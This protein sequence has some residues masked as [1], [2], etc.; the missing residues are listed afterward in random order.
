MTMPQ[1]PASPVAQ[2]FGVMLIIVGILIAL[3]C[4]LCTLVVIGT[5]LSM[6]GD[7]QGYGGGGMIGV[8]LIIGGIPTVVGGLLVWAGIAVLRGAR[9]RAT[10][11]KLDTFD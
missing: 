1:P 5:S 10:K 7:Q 9:K 8:A 4:G 2:F 3:L 6:P 11:V